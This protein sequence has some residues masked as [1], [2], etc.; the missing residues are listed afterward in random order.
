MQIIDILV[1][2]Q[3]N[4]MLAYFDVKCFSFAAHVYPS[5]NHAK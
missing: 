2:L 5:E 1:K 4:L 3:G